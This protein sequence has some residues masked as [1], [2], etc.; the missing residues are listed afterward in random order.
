MFK[1][2]DPLVNSVQKIM[3]ENALIRRV[4]ESLNEELGIASKKALPFEHH[5]NYDALL[6]QR[7]AEAKEG[8]T[9]RNERE[10]KLA[11]MH[12]DPKKITHGDV[13]KAR[14]VVEQSEE[15]SE[16]P[17]NQMTPAERSAWVK[18]QIQKGKDEKK[19][20]R[21]SLRAKMKPMSEQNVIQQKSGNPIP[22]TTMQRVQG[23]PGEKAPKFGAQTGSTNQ[24]TPSDREEMNKKMDSLKESAPKGEKYERMI[25]HIKA[26]YAKDGLTKNEKSIAYA[27]AWK[28]KNKE[29][30]KEDVDLNSVLEE[31]RA[32]LGEDAF[33]A[34]MAEQSAVE[35]MQANAA[36][37]A[38]DPRVKANMDAAEAA[39]EAAREAARAKA[40]DT[41]K[42]SG[43][44][45]PTPAEKDAAQSAAAARSRGAEAE[46]RK[47]YAPVD[48][49]TGNSDAE[50]AKAVD[51]TV[52]QAGAK[53]LPADAAQSGEAITKQ[54]ADASRVAS[55]MPTTARGTGTTAPKTAPTPPLPPARPANIGAD[56]P[57]PS[58]APAAQAAPKPAAPTPPPR[59][60]D[61]QP[62]RAAQNGDAAQRIQQSFIDRNK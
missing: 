52:M 31:I 9:P 39:K 56:R 10:A 21:S 26:K 23:E 30:M 50:R 8:S 42:P 5:A 25:K 24:V 11:A 41:L 61:L 37:Q 60:S 14:G 33:N 59:P 55:T 49:R 38:Q 1:K 15:T 54:V 19:R 57:A 4:T 40:F 58:A 16:K 36:R 51:K 3:Q 34:L 43:T 48:Q 45:K 53:N 62:N 46:V 2:N 17:L 22:P 44:I 28:A 29:E 20:L 18:D 27:T 6:E 13:L 35:K 47:N 7:L 12:G 32:N